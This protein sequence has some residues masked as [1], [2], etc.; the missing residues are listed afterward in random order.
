MSANL[1]MKTINPTARYL[2]MKT[3]A[4]TER[5]TTA[6]K[7]SNLFRRMMASITRHWQRGKMI[8]DLEAMDDRLLRDI[9][10]HRVD[11]ER[12]VDGFDYR[13]LRMVPLTPTPIMVGTVDDA[14]RKAA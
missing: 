13:E 12:V 7:N 14:D 4:P 2:T 6:N 3:N 8:K 11:I 10:L 1:T 5:R 9:G